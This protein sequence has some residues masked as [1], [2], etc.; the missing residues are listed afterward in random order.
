M[1]GSVAVARR[2]RDVYGQLRKVLRGITDSGTRPASARALPRAVALA[3]TLYLLLPG[4]CMA[5]RWLELGNSSTSLDKVY[6]DADSVQQ[7]DGYRIV[8]VMTAYQK[9]RA[10]KNNVMLD[11][12]IQKN[13]FDCGNK[14]FSGIQT[15]GYLN[16]QSV[17]SSHAAADW[18]DKLTPVPADPFSQRV[19][20]TACSL[21]LAGAH[22]PAGAGS[23]E[24]PGQQKAK[25]FSGSGIIVDDD[26]YVLTNAHVVNNCKSLVVKPLDSSAQP[27]TVE[28][29]DP[30]N[31]LALMKTAGGYGKPASFRAL[32]NPPKLGESIGVIGYPLVGILSSEPKATFGQVNSIAGMGNDYTLLQI[33]APVQAGN[34]G[35]PVLDESGNVIGIVVSQASPLLIAMAGNIPQNVNFAIRGE[36][37]QIF[38][39]AHGIKFHTGE[40]RK[41]LETEGIAAMGQSSTVLVFCSRE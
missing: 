40:S 19:L 32:S 3:F 28:A 8:L 36:I 21:P 33:S 9:P 7:I 35:G 17:G 20:S 34:S 14:T 11:S 16:G 22:S 37:A 24:V 1:G 6:I 13:A 12:H 2:A 18:K 26:G 39:Q 27:A 41:K 30:K 25:L 38:M 29:V 31:D 4:P 5:A 10:N 23:G 15:I